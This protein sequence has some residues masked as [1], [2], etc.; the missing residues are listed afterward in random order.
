MLQT[1]LFC[2]RRTPT[3]FTE[4]AILLFQVETIEGWKDLYIPPGIQPGEKLKFAQL[5]APDIKRPSHRGDHNFVIKVKIP[6]NIRCELPVFSKGISNGATQTDVFRPF[7]SA[8]T[9]NTLQRLDA[10]HPHRPS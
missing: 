9:K 10:K 1:F 3:S 4:K 2:A 8:W 6:K 7:A 5:G